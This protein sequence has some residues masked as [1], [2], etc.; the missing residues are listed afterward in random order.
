MKN[1]TLE[2]EQKLLFVRAWHQWMSLLPLTV[3]NWNE[4]NLFVPVTVEMEI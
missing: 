3:G 4:R 1:I 2:R